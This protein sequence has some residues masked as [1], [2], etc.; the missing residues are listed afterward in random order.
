VHTI[1]TSLM[2]TNI[3]QIRK[4]KKVGQRGNSRYSWW[5]CCSWDNNSWSVYI[6]AQG[7]TKE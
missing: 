2:V 3:V 1:S 7:L 6:F 5:C 4:G